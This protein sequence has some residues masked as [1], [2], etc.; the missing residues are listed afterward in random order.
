MRRT[1]TITQKIKPTYNKENGI[2]RHWTPRTVKTPPKGY[3][4]WKQQNILRQERVN[5]ILDMGSK[6]NTMKNKDATKYGVET[7]ET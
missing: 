2:E 1:Y 7:H 3:F 4:K 6:L 5:F